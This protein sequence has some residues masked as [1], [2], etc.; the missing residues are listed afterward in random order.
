[1]EVFNRIPE[2]SENT[3]V[4]LGFFDGLHLAHRAVISAAINEREQLVP[5]VFT[6]NIGNSA[7]PNKVGI[8]S[9][10]TQ[11]QKLLE[12][13]K[14]EVSIVVSPEYHEIDGIEPESFFEDIL[15]KKLKAR[16]V[17]CGYDYSF[18]RNA[19]G[20]IMLLKQLCEKHNIKLEVIPAL[21]VEG[22]E[23]SS[24]RIREAI[25]KGDIPLA[26]ELL[27]YEYYIFGKVM[28][29]LKIGNTI[30]FPTINQELFETQVM[31]K[32]GV[33]KTTSLVNGTLYQSVSSVGVKPTIAGERAPLCETYIVGYNGD[34]YG[35]DI[36]VSFKKMLREEVKFNSIDELKAQIAIDIEACNNE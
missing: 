35:L 24:S 26:N 16:F 31:P 9:I 36:K 6:F 7:P 3:A 33:Y 23:I 4:A 8:K 28:H 27:G 11:A 21:S 22:A 17:S 34:A 14:L 20:N 25:S 5:M 30:G 32:F 10:L 12:L 29:G 13:E 1:M 19:R 15:V 18:G 2:L